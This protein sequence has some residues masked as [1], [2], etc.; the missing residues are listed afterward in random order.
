M[1]KI[2]ENEKRPAKIS[3]LDGLL[4]NTNIKTGSMAEASSDK[5]KNNPLAKLL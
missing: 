4:K 1:D 5:P 2:A 3:P